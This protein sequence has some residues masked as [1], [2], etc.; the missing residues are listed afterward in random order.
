MLESSFL[1]IPKNKLLTEVNQYMHKIMLFIVSK[2][3][4]FNNE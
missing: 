4:E 2:K 3:I 1:F